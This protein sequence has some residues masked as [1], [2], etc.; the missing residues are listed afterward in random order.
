MAVFNRAAS[1]ML[2]TAGI[3]LAVAAVSFLPIYGAGENLAA[4]GKLNRNAWQAY[5]EAFR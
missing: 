4:G 5:A 3:V 1:V 2:F